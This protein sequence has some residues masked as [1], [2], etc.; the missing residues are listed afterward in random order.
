MPARWRL[1]VDGAGPGARNMA[2]DRAML[3]GRAAGSSPPTLRLYRWERPTLTL[4]RFQALNDA[5]L[6]LARSSG[7][8]VVRRPTGG[9]AVLHDD[10][11]TYS[12]VAALAD[13]VPRGTVASY[14][15]FAAAL[16]AA[17][18]DLGVET[19]V[20]EASRGQRG[21]ASCYLASTQADLVVGASKL[22]GSAQVWE[23]D[24]V[25]QHGS[26]VVSRDIGLE[27]ALLGLPPDQRALFEAETSTLES[28]AGTRPSI[29]CIEEA[30]AGGFES[31]LGVVL[32]P[33]VYT[34]AELGNA[35]DLDQR[36]RVEWPGVG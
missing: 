30:V 21:S 20:T 35:R 10:E 16:A 31:A 12:V 33:G 25:L 15:H 17:F 32:E 24:A 28:A 34:D 4:G 3:A 7:V 36:F 27:A 6:D 14:R 18:R 5:D 19:Q 13:G 11:V 2:L 23:R 22:S 26:F 8:D 29:A 9:R 1:I